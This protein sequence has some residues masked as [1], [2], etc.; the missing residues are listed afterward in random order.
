M[1]MS[2]GNMLHN[3]GS[4]IVAMVVL[5]AL[6]GSFGGPLWAEGTKQFIGTTFNMGGTDVEQLNLWH[7]GLVQDINQ[8]ILNNQNGQEC[9][10]MLSRDLMYLNPK[11]GAVFD[12]KDPENSHSYVYVFENGAKSQAIPMQ[13]NACYRPSGHARE[14]LD[15]TVASRDGTLM[16]GL[17]EDEPVAPVKAD[18]VI[19]SRD[20]QGPR[21]CFIRE[22]Y[23]GLSDDIKTC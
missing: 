2:D 17:F 23:Q 3:T 19:I 21:F 4:L 16:A 12:N 20:E 14:C 1:E 22:S 10:C 9:K 15:M 8:C 18:F 5:V 11:I 7:S 6:M 13:G